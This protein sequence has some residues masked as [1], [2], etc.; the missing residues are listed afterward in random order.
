M[1]TPILLLKMLR[2][3]VIGVVLGLV[4]QALVTAMLGDDLELPGASGAERL[5]P[6]PAATLRS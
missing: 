5:Q 3:V 1:R 6:P 4:V 2:A